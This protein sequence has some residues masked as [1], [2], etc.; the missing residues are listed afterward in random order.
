MWTTCSFPEEMVLEFLNW[1]YTSLY[2]WKR[3]NY[4][5]YYFVG[6]ILT[7]S[8]MEIK[9]SRW[10]N[11]A[12]LWLTATNK[13]VAKTQHVDVEKTVK[14]AIKSD[15]F[16]LAGFNNAS[17]SKPNVLWQYVMTFLTRYKYDSAANDD[18][19]F[20]PLPCINSVTSRS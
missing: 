17:I 19:L 20:H 14:G 10:L 3:E 2:L 15:T 6:K 12:L 4:Q 13:R 8:I 9:I 18:V 7:C 11:C 16:L 5:C 1:H